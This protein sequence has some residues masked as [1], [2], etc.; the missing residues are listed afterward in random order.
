MLICI[1]LKYNSS[2]CFSAFFINKCFQEE[3]NGQIS[4]LYGVYDQE[5]TQKRADHTDQTGLTFGAI[6]FLV[7]IDRYVRRLPIFRD[8]EQGSKSI[9]VK[10]THLP[11]AVPPALWSQGCWIAQIAR[12]RICHTLRK[13]PDFHLSWQHI[14]LARFVKLHI[15][16]ISDKD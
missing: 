13:N 5:E 12:P 14:F 11:L 4:C 8:I 7:C 1:V 2:K 9:W 6:R 16:D 15:N 10:K 3:K